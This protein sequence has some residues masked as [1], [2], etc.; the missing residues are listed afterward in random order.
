MERPL[1]SLPDET[2]KLKALLLERQQELAQKDDALARSAHELEILKSK[3]AWFEEQLRLARHKRFGASSEKHQHQ[4]D[5]FNEAEALVDEAEPVEE[6]EITYRR[7]KGKPGRR[8]LPLHLP[9]R[10]VRH[11]LSEAEKICA[12]C[13]EPLHCIGE[14][15]S[16]KLEIIPAKAQVLVHVRPKYACRRCEDGIKRAPLPPQPIPKS[17]ATAGLLAWVVTGKFL[18]R[19]PLYH[20]EGVL[21]RLQVDVSRTTLAAWMIRSAELLD[22]LYR[23]LHGALLDIDIV[24]VDETTVQVLKEPGK[25]AQSKSYLWVYRA[26]TGPPIT[27]YEYQPSRGAEHPQ[28][29]L[30]GFAGYLQ[31]DGYSAYQSLCANNAALR[32]VGCMAHVRRKFDEAEKAHPN[33]KAKRGS[34]AN[35]ALGLIGKLY[36]VEKRIRDL[37]PEGR[38]R[39]RQDIAKPLLEEFHTWLEKTAPRVAPQSLLGEAVTYALNQWP[40]L[41]SYLEDGRLE[42]DNNATERDIRPF[43][44]GRRAWNF[45]ATPRGA[46]ASAVLYSIVQTAK[47]NGLEPYSYLRQLFEQL[48]AMRP[49]DTDAIAAVL[50]WRVAERQAAPAVS[51][52]PDHA[53]AA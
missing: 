34:A 10:E 3:L 25:R 11:D 31:S 37:P 38:Y 8:P 12:C 48:P 47:A 23:A 20:L 28:R 33:R 41:L 22:P 39:V 14:E 24:Q 17:I 29:F 1:E 40:T 43:V 30:S 9:R 35:C 15:R 18:D 27:L 32:A 50:P 26:G 52:N 16:E 45:C 44:M 7:P 2:E 36:A 53:E 6:E 46:W 21:K 42:I 13:G 49:D 51:K 19:M 4:D 5:L